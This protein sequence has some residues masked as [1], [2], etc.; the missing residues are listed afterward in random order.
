MGISGDQWICECGTY[1][2]FLRK[3]CRD[4]ARPKSSAI[5]DVDVMTMLQK[6]KENEL[7]PLIVTKDEE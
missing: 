4:C 5:A 6:A 7:V 3:R 2:L 1:N